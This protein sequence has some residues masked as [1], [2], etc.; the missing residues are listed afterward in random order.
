MFVDGS[1]PRPQTYWS[2][3]NE[4]ATAIGLFHAR[5]EAADIIACDGHAETIKDFEEY[6]EPSLSTAGFAG[7]ELLRYY[8]PEYWYHINK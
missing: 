6:D 4:T 2:T 5:G 8:L 7:D 1:W 3:Y